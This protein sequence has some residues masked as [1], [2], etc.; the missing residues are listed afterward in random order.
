MQKTTSST[1]QSSSGKLPCFRK[2]PFLPTLLVATSALGAL[3]IWTIPNLEEFIRN[4]TQF[5]LLW[6]VAG[7]RRE[8]IRLFVTVF[9]PVVITLLVSGCCWLWCTIKPFVLAEKAE[10]SA[11][12]G[13]QPGLAM[14]PTRASSTQS[15]EMSV[16][17]PHTPPP[18]L[19]V[20]P[21]PPIHEEVQAQSSTVPSGAGAADAACSAQVQFTA[22][23]QTPEPS[24][25]ITAAPADKREPGA[26]REEK[27]PV[28]VIINL[29]GEVSMTVQTPDGAL[30][31][32]VSLSG[33]TIR[34][35][36]MAYIAWLQGKKVNRDKLLEEVFGH[37]KA[38][39]DA[40]PRKL[41]DA[42]DSHRKLIRQDLRQTIGKLNEQAGHEVVPPALDIFAN[43]QKLWWLA[44]TC[45]VPDLEAVETFY[46]V[47]EQAENAGQLA[48]SIPEAVRDAC[49]SLIAAYRGDFLEN[50]LR[51]HR[52]EFDPW[53][54]SWV[55]KP[56]T[57][58]RDYFLE[59]LWWAGSYALLAGQALN[60]ERDELQQQQQHSYYDRAA[61]Y[62]RTYAMR[63]CS[64]RFDL[65]V[66]F[67]RP[68]REHGERIIMSERA[69][70]R[71]IMLYG[72]MGS[73][74]MVDK[75]YSAY[76]KHIRRFSSDMW[77]P[78]PDT[79]KDLEAARSRTSAFR[80]QAQI[81]PSESLTAK[82]EAAERS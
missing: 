26:G 43:G 52:Y 77:E 71:C 51:D 49:E 1:T 53:A 61:R 68:G 72:A 21:I 82:L 23:E 12:D 66:S 33:N 35:Q 57:L 74:H 81:M 32:P 79:V 44:E 67:G 47:M 2:P 22:V 4:A 41:T 48:N 31:L 69:L 10:A 24:Q 75:V 40:T 80:L 36:L 45:R 15:T 20:T 27:P 16:S 17:S 42:F 54:N 58:Y 30:R 7:N 19:P 64:S 65:K 78:D 39:E 8:I 25:A 14:S 11:A 13:S 34:V 50:L 62:Y 29:L 46:R 5:S 3:V 28:Y 63:A 76:Y 73:T 70:R 6:Q 60:D 38:D 37:G 18:A 9:S 59:A 55:R 56:F